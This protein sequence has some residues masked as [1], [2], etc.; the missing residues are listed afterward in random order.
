[1]STNWRG[2]QIIEVDWKNG[3]NPVFPAN[4]LKSWCPCQPYSFPTYHPGSFASGKTWPPNQPDNLH[5]SLPF[6]C[7]RKRHLL[8]HQ[9]CCVLASHQKHRELA[10][11]IGRF[12]FKQGCLSHS[13]SDRHWLL[14]PGV[15][16]RVGFSHSWNPWKYG[17][18]EAVFPRRDDVTGWPH[19]WTLDSPPKIKIKHK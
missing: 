7:Q 14:K 6:S 10:D 17:S 18:Q 2:Q 1:M 13:P 19:S 3:E 12:I 4:R 16:V 15:Q 8:S 11:S 9:G 5:A